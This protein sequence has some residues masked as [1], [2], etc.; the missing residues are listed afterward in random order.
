[1]PT[2]SRHPASP[3]SAPG[4]AGPA[5]NACGSAASHRYRAVGGPVRR[6]GLLRPGDD[7][8][9]DELLCPA[10]RVPLMSLKLPTGQRGAA[11]CPADVHKV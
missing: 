7:G 10:L 6:D 11:P 1:M 3:I 5:G 8:W 9:T 4:A 2:D